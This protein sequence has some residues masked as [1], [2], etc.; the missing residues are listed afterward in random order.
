MEYISIYCSYLRQEAL[1]MPTLKLK[2]EAVISS[3]LVWEF[4]KA[5]FTVYCIG[6]KVM[7]V[8]LPI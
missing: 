8:S 6:V 2:H 1:L 4:V 3:T 7:S 5:L